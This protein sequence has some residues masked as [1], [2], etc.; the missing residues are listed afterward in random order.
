M[1]I[2]IEAVGRVRAGP[3]RDLIARYLD[4]ARTTGRQVG[5]TGFEVNEVPESRAA[6]ANARRAAEAGKL[7]ASLPPN[8][9][10]AVLDERGK[11]LTSSQFAARIESWRDA[12][13]PALAIVIGGPDGVDTALRDRA[14]LVLSLSPL[15]WP[16]RL[17]RVMVAEQLYRATAILTG[18]PY[19]RGD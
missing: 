6:S 14:D 17:V 19:H 3:E 5:L 16:H 15:T 8:A 4:R 10:L 1:R 9:R 11:H 7:G 2:A 18:H 13:A 12:A